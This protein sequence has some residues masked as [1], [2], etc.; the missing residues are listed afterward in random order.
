MSYCSRQGGHDGFPKFIV[1]PA[2]PA[3][4]LWRSAAAAAWMANVG[5]LTFDLPESRVEGA[6]TAS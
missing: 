2:R 6:T 4:E 3:A 1:F 5:S